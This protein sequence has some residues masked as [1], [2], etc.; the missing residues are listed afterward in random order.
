MCQVT[1]EGIQPSIVT[2]RP[3]NSPVQS[4]WEHVNTGNI[5]RCRKMARIDYSTTFLSYQ[6]KSRPLISSSP[7]H[8]FAT[9]HSRTGKNQWYASES[10]S[11]HTTLAHFYDYKTDNALSWLSNWSNKRSL[12][13]SFQHF[14]CVSMSQF[15]PNASTDC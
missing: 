10:M 1:G 8:C 5:K 11:V 13:S 14:V 3:L 2:I 7:K 4:L 12:R 9:F 6:I 15:W